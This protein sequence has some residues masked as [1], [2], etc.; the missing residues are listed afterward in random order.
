[1]PIYTRSGDA[2]TTSLCGGRRVEKD[3][4]YIEVC[5]TIDELS[6]TLGIVRTEKLPPDLDTLIARIQRELI[7][8]CS[9]IV[10][11]S[12]RILPEHVRQLENEIDRFESELPMLTGFIISGDNRTSTFLHLAR[13][14]CRRAERSLVTFQRTYNK[15]PQLSAYLNRLS[16]LLFV[17]A[18]MACESNP[19]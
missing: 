7:N 5:G 14:V 3:D 9:E 15:S 11:D 16:D 6:A 2:G 18:R 12:V 1:M 19:T 8:F 4:S 17:M 13:T 10:T